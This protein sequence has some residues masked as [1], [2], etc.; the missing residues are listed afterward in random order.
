MADEGG[1]PTVDQPPT[2]VRVDLTSLGADSTRM[3][4]THLGIPP[5]SPGATGW[6]MAFDV[7]ADALGR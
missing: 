4:M 5:G 6:N 3:T 2:E 7:L 1:T